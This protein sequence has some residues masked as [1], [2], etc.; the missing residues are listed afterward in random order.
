[1]TKLFMA[2]YL[3]FD[4]AKGT[5]KYRRRVPDDVKGFFRKGEFSKTLGKTE[6]E[7]MSNY[8]AFHQQVE[9]SIAAVRQ[10]P[11]GLDNVKL[12]ENIAEYLYGMDADPH[13]PGRDENERLGREAAAEDILRKYPPDPETGLPDVQDLTPE[14]HAMVVALYQGVDAIQ[15]ELTIETA[16]SFYLSEKVIADPHKRKKQLERFGRSKDALLDVTRGDIPLARVQRLHA[17]KLRDYYLGPSTVDTAKRNINDVKAVFNFAIREHDLNIQNPFTRL[18]FP[19]P[20]NQAIKDRLPL[21]DDV[22]SNM[23]GDLTNNQ[24]LLDIW[25]LM[26]HTGAQNAEILGL[27]KDDLHLDGGIPYVDIAPNEM[28]TLKTMSRRRFIP[29]VGLAL[30]V[31]KR[32]HAATGTEYLF[33][34]YAA[35]AKHGNFSQAV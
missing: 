4:K 22:I 2:R 13:S 30:D 19:E 9:R 20:T 17:R 33:P 26:H 15:A 7:A 12:K 31:G 34:R 24:T 11:K 29:L 5:H 18:D 23:Y 27:R 10:N 8:P 6:M 1:M 32:L 21:P 25:T 3:K 16:Y 14:D 35:T 28:R